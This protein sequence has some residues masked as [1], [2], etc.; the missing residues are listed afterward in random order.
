M[1]TGKKILLFLFLLLYSINSFPQT[2]SETDS[3]K[4]NYN[5]AIQF[6]IL[7]EVIAGYKYH[8]TES[9]AMRLIV[10]ATGAFNNK[11]AENIE[12]REN[13]AD[14]VINYENQQ[15]TT[16]DQFYEIKI[17]YLYYLKIHE[18]FQLFIGCGPFFSYRFE[19]N[20]EWYDRYYPGDDERYVGSYKHN[21]NTWTL[22]TS[23]LIGIE[24][25]VY[26]NVNLF[27]EYEATV[28]FGWQDIDDYFT[29]NSY[30]TQL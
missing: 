9:S 3:S 25:I 14:T 24:C 7:D 29:G 16:S 23:A 22:G 21:E 1:R 5:H 11:D 6:Y 13:R 30:S 2:D 15:V 27:V 28:S 18:I 12:Y 26:N 10:N 4:E 17:Q 8:F 20:E 19:Q